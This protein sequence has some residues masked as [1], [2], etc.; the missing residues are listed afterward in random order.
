MQGQGLAFLLD[1]GLRTWGTR[2]D[3]H[4]YLARAFL[5]RGVRPVFVFSEASNEL[6]NERFRTVGAEVAQINYGKGKLQ[7]YRQLRQIVRQHSITAVHIAFFNYFS[8][9]PWLARLCGVRYIV[10]QERNPGVLRA[11]SWKRSLVRLRTHVAALPM[12]RVIAISKFIMRQLV[13]VGIPENK[14][15]LVHHGINAKLYSPDQRAKKELAEKFSIQPGEIVLTALSYLKPHKNIDVILMACKELSNRGLA[16]RFFMIGDGEMRGQLE[17][18]SQ[19]LGIADK[20]HWLG[21]IPDP[22]PVLQACDIFL[23]VSTGE[24]FGLALAEGMACGPAVVASRSGAHPEIVEDGLSGLLVPPR[25]V[26]A[27][28]DAI[29]KL[30]ENK[31]L[32]LE[33]AR[34]GVER[35]RRHFTIET[36]IEN[37]LKVYESLWNCNDNE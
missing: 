19:Q 27:L 28:A 30:A 17:N 21:H 1:G 10:Y 25:D 23:M 16:V 13:E 6:L 33:M 32:R 36:S 37:L 26:K 14:I 35:V 22:V 5:S 12:T 9:V 18:M 15:F 24:G 20:V 2:E 34:H 4:L 11:S 7:Y 31:E 8:A 3:L 29:Y